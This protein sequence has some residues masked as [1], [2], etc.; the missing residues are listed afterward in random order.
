MGCSVFSQVTERYGSM[1]GR[2]LD[3]YLAFLKHH[4][5][6]CYGQIALLISLFILKQN[7][8]ECTPSRSCWCTFIRGRNLRG[9]ENP[10]ASFSG[11]AVGWMPGERRGGPRN[12]YI[13]LQSIVLSRY[14]TPEF[15]EK[16]KVGAT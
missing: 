16:R 14:R 8:K 6:R 15:K 2:V 12:I 11:A 7:R 5:R 4:I 10:A 9:S 3:P 13:H 1:L